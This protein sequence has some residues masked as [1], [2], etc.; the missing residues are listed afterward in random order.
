[1]DQIVQDLKPTYQHTKTPDETEE[2]V[3]EKEQARALTHAKNFTATLPASIGA[4]EL[5][6]TKVAK[7]AQQATVAERAQGNARGLNG[8]QPGQQGNG[9]SGN[10][11]GLTGMQPGQQG[12]GNGL[13]NGNGAAN[14]AANSAGNG[15]GAANSAANSAGNGNS[16]ANSASNANS[17]ANNSAN[18]NNKKTK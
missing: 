16:A 13:G 6:V 1:M 3:K 17:A 9:P 11:F 7:E 10:A 5:D 8:T 15:N 14:S 12:N 18:N 2:A 4:Q